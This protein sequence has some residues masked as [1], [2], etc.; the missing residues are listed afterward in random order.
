MRC[1]LVVGDCRG[2]HDNHPAKSFGW[3]SNDNTTRRFG[4]GIPGSGGWDAST[5]EKNLIQIKTCGTSYG[6]HGLILEVV[7]ATVDLAIGFIGLSQGCPTRSSTLLR[8]NLSLTLRG[9]LFSVS[10]AA[11]L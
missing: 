7:F 2:L 3:L 8:R 4:W 5:D 10:D 1:D 11:P 6:P 9:R